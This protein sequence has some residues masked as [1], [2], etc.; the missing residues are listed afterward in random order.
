M[1]FDSIVE[2]ITADLR[3]AGAIGGEET[4]RIADLL[5][6]GVEPSIRLHV[7]EALYRAAKELEESSPGVSVEIRL[8][9]RNPVLSLAREEP[10]GGA[11]EGESLGD[12]AE[13]DVLRITLR[14]PEGL[15]VR[16]EDAAARAGASVNAWIVAALARSFDVSATTRTQ[17]GGRMPRRMTGFVKG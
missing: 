12:Y 14:L 9:G 10:E 11:A 6:A 2:G 7:L 17:P 8:E 3:R 16:V 1:E 4:A 15:K 13:D 5:V